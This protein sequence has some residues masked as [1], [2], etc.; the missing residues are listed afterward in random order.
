MCY[1]LTRQKWSL[2]KSLQNK[3]WRRCKEKGFPALLVGL[4]V[5]VAT[6]ENSMEIPQKTKDRIAT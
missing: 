5:G 3:C 4:Q 1:H 6:V 2:L